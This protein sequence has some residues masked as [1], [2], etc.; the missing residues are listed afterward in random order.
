MIDTV[1]WVE[2]QDNPDERGRLTAIEADRHVPFPIAR[3]FLVH[4]V[5]PGTDRGGH[6]HR[7]T[8]QVLSCAHGRVKV[9]VSDGHGTITF[10]LDD[11]ARG[12]F[13]PR[14]LWIRLYDFQQQA[15]LLVYANTHYDRSRSIR[16]WDEYLA[17]VGA[18]GQ[19]QPGS[20][21]GE[22]PRLSRDGRTWHRVRS[23]D[24]ALLVSALTDRGLHTIEEFKQWFES[25]RAAASFRVDRRPLAQL[26]GWT[27]DPDTGNLV[28][29][30][31]R[32]FQIIGVDVQTSFGPTRRWT[33]PI[34]QQDEVGI[35]G[36]L[37][38]RKNGVLHFLVQAKMEPGNTNLLQISPTVQATQSNF[39]QVHG[40]KR[41]PYVDF[42]LN[43]NR[44]HVV[45]DRLQS[46]Q[47]SRFLRKRNRNMIMIVPDHVDVPV[48]DD[49]KWL[50][51]AQIYELLGVQN[52]IN[53][54]SR[55]VLCGICHPLP[56]K[57]SSALLARQPM[58]RFQE[59]LLRSISAGSGSRTQDASAAVHWLTAMKARY[60]LNVRIV[61][62]KDVQDW[63]NDG[64]TIHHCSGRFFSVIGV[65]VSASTREVVDWDQPLI[66][67]A[68][69][70]IICFLC[71]KIDG[72]LHFLV[73][74]RVEPGSFDCVDMG[75]TLQFT[76]INY[77]APQTLPLPPFTDL[78]H[79]LR[80]DQIRYDSLQSEEGGRFYHDQNRCIVAETDPDQIQEIPE[81][82]LWMTLWQIKQLLRYSSCFHLEARSLLAC[83]GLHGR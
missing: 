27:I 79:R 49:F 74:A 42:F 46:E 32:F 71:Q 9:D 7:D 52:L 8:D 68:K 4:R 66:E 38:Q 78:F 2:F 1:H 44:D 16:T 34:I 19:P 15:V 35:L 50:T 75:P 18:T 24:S 81:N 55:T 28:H 53:V 72:V 13:V 77:E 36:F 80:P 51:L 6:A 59:D 26:R 65:S 40:G 60:D 67:S 58:A 10:V 12:L 64:D 25:R 11:P 61:R 31:G 30:S 33:Q 63:T 54:D 39:T 29:Q 21:N 23:T 76:P 62:L 14:M 69:G 56:W 48:Y 3:V 73:Q 17:A 82:Y 43:Y 20:P 57:G 37:A 41:P 47:G 70:G 5:A 45:C 22:G 83:I